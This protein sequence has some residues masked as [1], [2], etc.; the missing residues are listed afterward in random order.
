MT[1]VQA[2]LSFF[3]LHWALW[4]AVSAGFDQLRFYLILFNCSSNILSSMRHFACLL[5]QTN[6]IRLRSQLASSISSLF[7]RPIR[8][9]FIL[10]SFKDRLSDSRISEAVVCAAGGV[11]TS[12]D[13]VVALAARQARGIPLNDGGLRQVQIA[14]RW[15]RRCD[16]RHFI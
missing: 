1:P 7:F 8:A 10:R 14:W 5:M 2:D 3:N 11:D 6:H 12:I 13:V 15:G 4:K 16:C 9:A